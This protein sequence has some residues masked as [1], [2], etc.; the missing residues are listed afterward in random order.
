MQ[1][2]KRTSAVVQLWPTITSL[3]PSSLSFNLNIR[4]ATVTLHLIYLPIFIPLWT[5]FGSPTPLGFHHSTATVPCYVDGCNKCTPAH[6][7]KVYIYWRQ[8]KIIETDW[9]KHNFCCGG[10]S[11]A[12]EL[13]GVQRCKLGAT[14]TTN[15][16]T[17]NE[18]SVIPPWNWI[19]ITFVIMKF[20]SAWAAVWWWRLQL[21]CHG[22]SHRDC[23]GSDLNPPNSSSQSSASSFIISAPLCV[24]IQVERSFIRLWNMGGERAS[25]NPFYRLTTLHPDLSQL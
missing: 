21:G 1:S 3:S 10:A 9:M 4:T 5:K 2:N 16:Y 22:M 6:H 24:K 19:F 14:T 18:T 25:E 13:E 17:P 20:S 12:L 15:R 11:D 8:Y 23:S 7:S